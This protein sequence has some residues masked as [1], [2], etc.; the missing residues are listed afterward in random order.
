M[1]EALACLGIIFMDMDSAL[2]EYP[3]LVHETFGKLVKPSD[4]CFAAL[5]GAV[6][7]GGSFIYVE[8]GV[9]TDV[10]IHAYFRINAEN[11][12]QLART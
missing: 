8:L 1:R 4:N 11:T 7:S 2:C 10:P 12:G 3:E 6:W 9:Q 5:N